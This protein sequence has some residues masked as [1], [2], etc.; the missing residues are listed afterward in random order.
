LISS[1][2]LIFL[3]IRFTPEGY[4]FGWSGETGDGYRRAEMSFLQGQMN[5]SGPHH[6]GAEGMA[7]GVDRGFFLKGDFEG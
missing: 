4:E 2:H 7:S 3:L 5:P 6:R 1:G